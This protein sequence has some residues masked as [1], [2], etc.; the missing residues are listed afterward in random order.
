MDFCWK[1]TVRTRPPP[2]SAVV[3]ITHIIHLAKERVLEPHKCVRC[4]SVL[5]LSLPVIHSILL[6]LSLSL[7]IYLNLYTLDFP[8]QIHSLLFVSVLNL[9]YLFKCNSFLLWGVIGITTVSSPALLCCLR[10][11]IDSPDAEGGDP[12]RGRGRGFI[13]GIGGGSLNDEASEAL[14]R[15]SAD[16][17]RSVQTEEGECVFEMIETNTGK[18]ERIGV[19]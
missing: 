10:G 3:V 15:S 19:E 5:S 13:K 16:D 4:L 7:S 12:P 11:F 9:F 6:S 18:R 2:L 1:T 17:D 8:H 14:V